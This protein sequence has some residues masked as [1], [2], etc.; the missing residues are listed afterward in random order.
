MIIS[1]YYNFKLILENK[2]IIMLFC[3]CE[4]LEYSGG[5]GARFLV[6]LRKFT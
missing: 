3:V 6:N 5:P 2:K 1:Q 4:N